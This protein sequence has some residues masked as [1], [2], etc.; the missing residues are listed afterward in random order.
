MVTH[1]IVLCLLYCH[2][3]AFDILTGRLLAS[4]RRRAPKPGRC[5]V[6]GT[7][8]PTTTRRRRVPRHVIVPV[9]LTP[10]RRLV[11][12]RVPF[13]SAAMPESIPGMLAFIV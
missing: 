3:H 13:G 1:L 7:I 10:V 2:Y 4:R 6:P 9:G 8:A 12:K 5:A 11:G